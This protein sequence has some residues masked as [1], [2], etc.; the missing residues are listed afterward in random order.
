MGWEGGW[1]QFPHGTKSGGMVE[2]EMVI[3][4]GR[5]GEGEGSRGRGGGK[6]PG[7]GVECFIVRGL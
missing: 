5:G 7:E 6:W 4:P 1:V 2:G 3:S